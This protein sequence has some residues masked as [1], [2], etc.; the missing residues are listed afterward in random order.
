MLNNIRDI[1]Y[2]NDFF[3]NCHVTKVLKF[4]NIQIKHI[5]ILRI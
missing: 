3:F 4:F 2:A 1:L 5:V